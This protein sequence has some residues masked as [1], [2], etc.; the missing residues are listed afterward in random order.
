[1][2]LGKIS[3]R[4]PT[5]VIIVGVGANLNFLGV[6]AVVWCVCL[7]RLPDAIHERWNVCPELVADHTWRVLLNV[8]YL[9][10][11]IDSRFYFQET[12]S[13]ALAPR[14]GALQ[15]PRNER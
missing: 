4:S 12:V 1:M 3:H 14:W 13:G 5:A 15:V 10:M 11:L 9:I 6:L 7:V 8:K 2:I